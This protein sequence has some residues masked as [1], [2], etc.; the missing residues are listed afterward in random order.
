ML[1]DLVAVGAL[2]F[3]LGRAAGIELVLNPIEDVL[4]DNGFVTAL[5][6][7]VAISEAAEADGVS[8]GLKSASRSTDWRV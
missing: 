5:A 3:G 8:Q 6:D 2:A 4:I 7:R 1:G